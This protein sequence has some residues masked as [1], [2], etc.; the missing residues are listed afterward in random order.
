MLASTLSRPRWAIPMTT[1][2]VPCSVASAS[3]ASSSAMTVSPPS[4][5]NRFCPMYLVCRK[6]SNASALFSRPRMYFCSSIGGFSCL[7]STRCWIHRRC[8][9]SMMCMYS[10]PTVRQ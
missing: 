4:S 5:E 1:S 10:T 6:V 9:G 2:A 8:T 3:A 7:T